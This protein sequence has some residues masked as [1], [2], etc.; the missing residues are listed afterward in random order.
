MVLVP[1]VA[2]PTKL[3]V[4]L[5][6]KRKRNLVISALP[7]TMVGERC[8]LG[9]RLQKPLDHITRRMLRMM[10]RVVT[11]DMVYLGETDGKVYKVFDITTFSSMHLTC[12]DVSLMYVFNE[13]LKCEK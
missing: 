10:I 13:N 7:S 2:Q 9:H 8:I 1:I 3:R 12:E 11:V 6:R 5:T 4:R